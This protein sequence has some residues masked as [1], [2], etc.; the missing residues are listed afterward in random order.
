MKLG[1][2]RKLVRRTLNQYGYDACRS[3]RF[4]ITPPDILDLAIRSIQHEDFFF[5]QVG[6]NDGISYDPIRPYI[7][8]YKWK[9]ILVEPQEQ[10]FRLLQENYKDSQQLIF[11]QCAITNADG[12]ISLYRPKEQSKNSSEPDTLARISPHHFDGDLEKETV[13]GMTL[14]SLLRKH[15]VQ[16]LDFLQVDAEGFDD[17]IVKQA[18]TLPE[19]LIPRLIQFEADWL[20]Y[21]ETIALYQELTRHGYRIHP[22]KWFPENDTIA[23][24]QTVTRPAA[25]RSPA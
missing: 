25:R 21:E 17:Q 9:G 8:E 2:L 19:A 12:P 18:L 15:N 22:G 13:P 16:R 23:V 11:E 20:P 10:I 24:K 7:L 14:S 5:I 6:A 3:F 4:W 1:H